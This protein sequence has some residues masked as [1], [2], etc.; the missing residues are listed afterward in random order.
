VS[1]AT[2]AESRKLIELEALRGIAA[3]V[4]FVHHF[5]LHYLPHFHGRPFPDDPFALVRTPL[6]ALINGSAAVAVFFVLSGFVL[7]ARAFETGTQ[8]SLI[9]G[10]LKRWPRLAL[11][12]VVANIFSGLLLAAG[13][14]VYQDRDWLRPD[15]YGGF[16]NLLLSAFKEGGVTTFIYGYANFNVVIW[17]M[18][19][20]FVGSLFAYG[21]AFAMLMFRSLTNSMLCGLV[22]L[23]AIALFTGSGAGLYATVIV[24]VLIARLYV[25][26]NQV[27]LLQ[28]LPLFAATLIA[29][30]ILCGFDGYSK[31][32]GFYSFMQPF[33][34]VS[35]GRGIHALG[36]T[37]L[38]VLVLSHQPTKR[39]LAGHVGG[40]LGRLSFP[41][42]LVHPPI[43][44]G[45]IHPL[46]VMLV[47]KFGE[48]FAVPLCFVTAVMLTL[49]FA[50]PLLRLDEW[51]T[52][53]LRRIV[54]L[55]KA[56][57]I[58]Q[59]GRTQ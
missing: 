29:I 7:T 32:S 47:N 38:V 43:L 54:S 3:C 30:I 9:T 41:I 52:D 48:G 59:V 4:V 35:V 49:L 58:L 44:I 26:G 20:E 15:S 13:L 53:Y 50:Y 23:I 11:P 2:A 39:L 45:L 8:Q 18:H 1:R 57:F 34:S 25:K 42:Y 31:P 33:A 6:F 12:V 19:Y 37:L 21:L 10:S 28:R 51:W 17:T 22:G 14:F 56:P 16:G 36:A 5:L 24:G 27:K 55:A 46:H 40:Y